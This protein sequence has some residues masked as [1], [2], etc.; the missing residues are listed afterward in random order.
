VEL[1]IERCLHEV[2]F[3]MDATAACS[4]PHD[5]GDGW[6]IST[7]DAAGLDPDRLRAVVGWLDALD[8]AN[9]HSILV[10][11]RGSIAFEHYRGTAN[12]PQG[13]DVRHD[14]RSVTKVVTGL[15]VGAALEKGYELSLDAAI[16]SFFPEYADLRTPVKDRI[17]VRHVLTMSAGL[18]WDENVAISNPNHGEVRLW[19]SADRIR[20]ALEPA[21]VAPPG[22]EWNYSGGSTEILGAILQKATGKPLDELAHELLLGPLDI[23]DVEWIRHRDASPSASGGLHMRPRDLAKIG[24]L[25]ANHGAWRGRS[26]IAADWIREG[27][28]PQIGASDRLFFYGYHWWLGRSLVERKEVTWAAGIGLGGQRLFFVPAYDLVVVMTAGHYED[29]MQAWVPLVILNR[30]ILRAVR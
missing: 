1:Q 9:V 14:L 19:H 17:L 22:A 5:L 4:R 28:S 25:V 11:R 21:C 26:L 16:F 24:L 29:A 7:P 6:S 13:P 2:G 30:F 12:Q 18:A 3:A 8:G 27:T 23:M 10:V 20:T 15:L